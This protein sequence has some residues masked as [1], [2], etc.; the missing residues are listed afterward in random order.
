MNPET[1]LHDLK[2]RLLIYFLGDHV[3]ATSLT[4]DFAKAISSKLD[5]DILHLQSLAQLPIVM[6]FMTDLA[7]TSMVQASQNWNVGLQIP[8]PPIPGDPRGTPNPMFV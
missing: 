5:Q 8:I 1:P 7:R 4:T 3:A 6:S 2:I